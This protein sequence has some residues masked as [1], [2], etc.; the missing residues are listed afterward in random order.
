M[1][2]LKKFLGIGGAVALLA[3]CDPLVETYETADSYD[4]VVIEVGTGD[5]NVMAS[6]DDKIRVTS[7]LTFSEEK[8]AYSVEPDGRGNLVVSAKCSPTDSTCTTAIDVELPPEVRVVVLSDQGN[9][10]ADGIRSGGELTANSGNLTVSDVSG[11]FTLM[12]AAG[13]IEGTDLIA[14]AVTANATMGAIDLTFSG[15]PTSVTA[16]TGEGDI[17]INV[18]PSVAYFVDAS[19]GRGNVQVDVPQE[20]A[21]LYMI[22][23]HADIGDV[24]IYN[25]CEGGSSTACP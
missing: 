6:S 14:E 7:T 19:S 15:A 5:V 4:A 11:T 1:D 20:S 18:P 21:S 17:T 8:P 22:T 12:A 3:A 16:N 10:S 23:A 9:V 25:N 2:V 24:G 13:S